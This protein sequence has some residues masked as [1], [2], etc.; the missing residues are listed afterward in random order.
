M[1]QTCDRELGRDLR[2]IPILEHGARYWEDLEAALVADRPRI[3]RRRGRLAWKVAV[4]AVAACLVAVVGLA[5]LPGSRAFERLGEAL[6]GR[7]VPQL[8]A[9]GPETAKAYDRARRALRHTRTVGA[10]SVTWDAYAEGDV[11]TQTITLQMGEDGSWRMETRNRRDGGRLDPFAVETYDFPSNTGRSWGWGTSAAGERAWREGR[12][13]CLLTRDSGVLAQHALPTRL[14][15]YRT[16]ALNALAAGTCTVTDGTLLGRPT[17]VV[18]QPIE[19]P[20][21]LSGSGAVEAGYRLVIDEATGLLLAWSAFDPEGRV[22]ER[23]VA[24]HLDLTPEFAGGSP[25]TGF[26]DGVHFVPGHSDGDET[27]WLGS[28]TPK[29]PVMFADPGSK[30]RRVAID[31]LVGQTP[32]VTPY[33]PGWVPSGL[34][35]W[36]AVAAGDLDSRIE[37]VYRAGLDYLLVIMYAG[38]SEPKGPSREPVMLTEGAFAGRTAWVEKPTSGGAGQAEI[39]VDDT[40][41][42]VTGTLS[43]D[44]MLHVLNSFEA[45]SR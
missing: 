35:L 24:T 32:G 2:S 1:S 19:P 20:V 29:H 22:V 38:G 37:V 21:T 33:L 6:F 15:W 4:V 23:E 9:I 3:A 14:M 40:S 12:P 30:A 44:E 36:E 27:D 5:G 16:W 34:T 11:R 17:L 45:P 26:P 10:L 13:P 43:R 8:P 25:A 42:Y 28:A 39:K 31:N 41:V 18:A 7:D